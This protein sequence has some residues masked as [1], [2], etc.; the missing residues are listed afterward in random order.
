MGAALLTAVSLLRQSGVPAT[1]T[2]WAEDGVVFYADAVT[3]SFWWCLGAAYNGYGQLLPRLGAELAR[4]APQRDAA[5]VIALAGAMTLAILSCLIFHMARAHIPSPALRLVLVAAIAL[6]PVAPVEMLDNLVNVPWWL[7]LAAFWA[8]L[9]RPRHWAGKVTAGLICLLAVGSE[10]LA[11]LLL[12][13]VLARIVTLRRVGE[14]SASAGFA[15]GV[16]YQA[17]VVFSNG[18][19]HSFG[20]ATAT[21]IPQ[22]LAVRVGLEWLAGYQGTG[23]LY[24][25]DQALAI[26]LGSLL[27]AGALVAGLIPVGLAA[28]T[29]PAR[30]S[31][32]Y[33]G[34]LGAGGALPGGPPAV[35]A[36][37]GGP[38]AGG[39]LL[40]GP[41]AGGALPGGPPAGRAASVR[42]FTA[43]AGLCALVC[44]AVPV[45]L[46]GAGP[47]MRSNAYGFGG[48][49]EA[50]PVLMILSVVLVLAGALSA[51][52]EIKTAGIRL[53]APGLLHAR[54]PAPHPGRRQ[55]PAALVCTALLVPGW[56]A[57]F[58]TSNGRSA[59]P[60]W[61]S[62]LNQARAQ[63]LTAKPT[64]PE[65][66][67]I[68]PHG[69][70]VLLECRYISGA[71]M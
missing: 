1:Q 57:G 25:H 6:L 56:A 55:W 16:A 31:A 28:G 65:V 60:T 66:I 12:P 20:T 3:R 64:S 7:L 22:A 38:P 34:P 71:G 40:G 5:T 33:P 27:L 36:L 63:C 32:P 47:I 2:M 4:L 23:Q 15:L 41:P 49:Y 45:W 10:P 39:A 30:A 59:G 13:L 70:F 52:T 14:N 42:A 69:R 62:Q 11:G 29:K 18:G 68:D 51:R 17:A 54:A 50:A 43:A 58:R 35:G 37:L 61:Q 19:E 53:P 8:L 21:G 26:A 9:W 46:R 48:R 44:F 67:E 24:A